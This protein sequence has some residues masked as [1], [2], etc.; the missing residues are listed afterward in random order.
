MLMLLPDHIAIY[1]NREDGILLIEKRINTVFG[2]AGFKAFLLK[3][4]T[5]D[6]R[7]V[8]NTESQD[9]SQIYRIILC[10][11]R[12]SPGDSYMYIGLRCL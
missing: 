1:R 3:M 2:H 6:C 5:T 7:T 4:W 11:L 12:R 10:S 9:P 8:R